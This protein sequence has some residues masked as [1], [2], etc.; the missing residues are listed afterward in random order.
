[1][2]EFIWFIGTFLVIY[3]FQVILILTNKK[4]L[5]KYKTSREVTYL[6][7]KYKFSLDNINFKALAN[8]L[9]LVNSIIIS[10]TMSIIVNVSENFLIMMLL[11]FGIL[12]VLLLLSYHVIGKHYKR[13]EDKK[14]VS[15]NK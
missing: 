12:T 5:E 6:V 7:T 11:S 10:F 13:K 1:M 2:K 9:F 3:L 4:S 14:C 8:Q 15:I